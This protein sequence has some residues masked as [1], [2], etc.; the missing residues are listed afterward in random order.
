M[1]ALDL[2][3]ANLFLSAVGMKIGDWNQVC[4]RHNQ[5]Y[6][7]QHWINYRAPKDARKLHN[8]AQHVSK[9]IHA[10]E[11]KL[12]QVDNSFSPA[13]DEAFLL[14][15][16]LTGP[17]DDAYLRPGSTIVFDFSQ[18]EESNKREEWLLSSVV[19]LFLLFEA[20]GQL[21]SSSS[22]KGTL[23]SFQDGYVYFMSFDLEEIR[24]AREFIER[25]EKN[26]L[27]EVD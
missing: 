7:R 22:A 12:F 15:R 1:R 3:Q 26:P 5:K 18:N 21:V 9:W 24:R 2:T 16:L 25:F 6:G 13:G 8:F 14:D 19:F 4:D 10:G 20:H 27:Q 23:L 11:W 17:S